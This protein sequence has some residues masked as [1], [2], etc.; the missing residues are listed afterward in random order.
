M[1]AEAAE[2]ETQAIERTGVEAKDA[3]EANERET[4]ATDKRR[5][6]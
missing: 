3:H 4:Q 2:M 1:K 5:G 6:G